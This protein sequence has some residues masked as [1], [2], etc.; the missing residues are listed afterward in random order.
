MSTRSGIIR[1]IMGMIR[2]SSVSRRVKSP[3]P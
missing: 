2:V 3:P 1:T